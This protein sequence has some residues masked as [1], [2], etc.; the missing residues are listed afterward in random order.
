MQA[1]KWATSKEV[2]ADI[3]SMSFGSQNPSA[4]IHDAIKNSQKTTGATGHTP[5]LFAAASNHGLLKDASFP[6]TDAN[7]IC[8]FALDGRGFD[9]NT[10]NPPTIPEKVNFGTLGH[11]IKLSWKT[12]DKQIPGEV[13]QESYPEELKSGSSYS[14]PILA[15]TAA[16]YLAWLD[17]HIEELGP[18]RH[19]L[20]REK[21]WVVKIFRD[22]MSRKQETHS[23]MHF[24]VPWKLF[25]MSWVKDQFLDTVELKKA[26]EKSTRDTLTTIRLSMKHIND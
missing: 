7:V 19:K 6:G 22:H 2:K 21:E 10:F 4:G 3:I 5:L 25:Q 11:G 15:A 16:N 26:D 12:L 14:T 20:A 1:I 23:D 24:V 17:C 13:R 9:V 18:N 8:V